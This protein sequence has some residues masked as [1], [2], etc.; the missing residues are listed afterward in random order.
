MRKCDLLI[1]GVL[2]L[3]LFALSG[4]VGAACI[5]GELANFDIHNF[6]VF[7]VYSFELVLGGDYVG[8]I[9][10][11]YS[12]SLYGSPAVSS[13]GGNTIIEWDFYD[14]MPWCTWIHMGVR[15]APGVSAPVVMGSTLRDADGGSIATLPFPWQRWE[16]TVECPVIDIIDPNATIPIGGVWVQRWA[17]MSWSEIPLQNLTVTDPMVLGLSWTSYGGQVLRS[18]PDSMLTLV[19]LTSGEEAAVVRYDVSSL[20]GEDQ[21]VRFL[22]EAVLT[23]GPS[24]SEQSTW[25][26]IKSM[27][28]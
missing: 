19:L 9:E 12:S 15:L 11:F 16:G 26:R 2:V 5:D 21:Y 24:A 22:S 28:R 27:Y 13:E 3:T 25:G 7:D 8:K 10:S 20:G 6:T 4:T 1:A 14:P 23:Y 18:D 17:A